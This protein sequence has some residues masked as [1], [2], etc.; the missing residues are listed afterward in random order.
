MLWF[1]LDGF[2]DIVIADD[3]HMRMSYHIQ[4]KP[5][6]KTSKPYSVLGFPLKAKHK[7]FLSEKLPAIC[8]SY[9]F[10]ISAGG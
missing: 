10:A 2:P 7:R 6:E 4:Q 1:Y 9:A 5:L 3:C 8:F